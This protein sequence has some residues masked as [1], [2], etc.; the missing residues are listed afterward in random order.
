MP[1]R[2][3]LSLLDCLFILL[4]ALLILTIPKQ[5]VR[6]SEIEQKA[7]FLVE[8]VWAD[9]SCSDIDIWLLTPEGR[10][11]YYG[12]KQS[13]LYS[14]DRDDLGCSNDTR[15][16]PDGTQ[17]V[18][19]VNREIVTFRGWQAGTYAVNL[20]VFAW[21]DVAPITATVRLIRLNPYATEIERQIA[22]EAKGQEI[23]FASFNLD[24]DGAL[25]GV[26]MEP[27]NITGHK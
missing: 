2:R 23:T 25:S 21:S 16:N 4:L 1:E 15:Q 24:N 7:E 18:I 9:E 20:F 19:H 10:K 3:S 11:V 6:K 5:P 27:I 8:L 26:S 13:G 22:L 14:I 12:N 17:T